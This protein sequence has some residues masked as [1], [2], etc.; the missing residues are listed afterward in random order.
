MSTW[1]AGENFYTVMQAQKL[2][3]FD[4]NMKL[5]EPEFEGHVQLIDDRPGFANFSGSQ[6]RLRV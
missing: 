6:D 2:S 4:A 3:I 5:N 1:H